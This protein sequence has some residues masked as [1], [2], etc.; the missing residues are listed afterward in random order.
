MTIRFAWDKTKNRFNQRK[1]DGIAFEMAVQVFCDSF[2]LTRQ[3]R[4]EN[5]EER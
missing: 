2:R 3:D 4:I 5:G 1:H